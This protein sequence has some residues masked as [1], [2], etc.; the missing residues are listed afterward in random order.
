MLLR[1]F[2]Y[3]VV[4][5]VEAGGVYVVVQVGVDVVLIAVVDV[6]CICCCS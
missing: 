1:D 2:A 6:S 3:R 4:G 5:V